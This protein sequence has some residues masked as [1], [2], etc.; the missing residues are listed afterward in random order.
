VVSSDPSKLSRLAG[1]TQPT[2]VV[3]GDNDTMI[4][5][6]NTHILARH[7]PN[8]RVRIFPDGAHGFLYQ[9]P[10]EF[11]DLVGE[12]PHVKDPESGPQLGAAST[13]A[14]G[15]AQLTGMIRTSAARLSQRET[16]RARRSE[17]VPAVVEV[18]R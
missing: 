13:T 7:P 14:R 11:A 5:T 15:A 1:I 6:E 10:T 12:I 17:D 8:A 3:N 4:P 16:V 2:L 9:C 18:R